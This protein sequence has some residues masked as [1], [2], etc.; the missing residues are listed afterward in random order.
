[1]KTRERILDVAI[2]LFNENGTNAVSTNHIAEAAGI[3]PGNLYYHFRNK[4]AIINAIYNRMSV[5]WA[6]IHLL[7]AGQAPTLNDLT[8]IVRRNFEVLMPYRFFY[9]EM[10]LLIRNDA[11]LQAKYQAVRNGGFANIEYLLTQ[12]INAGIAR[13]PTPPTTMEDLAALVWLVV[14]FWLVFVELG[15]DSVTTEQQ[16]RGVHLLMQVLRPYLV[17]S[18]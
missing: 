6:D 12:F 16:E 11:E 1:M 7:P 15:G 3:S 10:V 4:E 18:G 9:R 13:A 5:E 8:T 17:V 2:Q 14:E